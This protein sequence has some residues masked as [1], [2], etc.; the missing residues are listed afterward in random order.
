MNAILCYF[1][2][3]PCRPSRC[4]P[5]LSATQIQIRLGKESER[6]RKIE[7][8][9]VSVGDASTAAWVVLI[10]IHPPRFQETVPLLPGRTPIISR[11]VVRQE[12]YFGREVRLSLPRLNP[13]HLNRRVEAHTVT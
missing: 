5:L 9:Y 6:T 7:A 13:S 12:I 2:S 10:D 1:C 4:R 11:A 3:Q 8:L